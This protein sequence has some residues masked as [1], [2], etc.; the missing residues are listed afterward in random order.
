MRRK[1]NPAESSSSKSSEDSSDATLRR[2]V[3][4]A[5]LSTLVL[6]KAKSAVSE[7][8]SVSE[9]ASRRAKAGAGGRAGRDLLS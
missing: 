2:A 9:A 1:A 7:S 6:R 3:E 8:L 4:E 5:L